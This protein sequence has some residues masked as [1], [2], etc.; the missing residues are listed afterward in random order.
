[1]GDDGDGIIGFDAGTSAVPED[2]AAASASDMLR[3]ASC[4]GS[5]KRR[6]AVSTDAAPSAWLELDTNCASRRSIEGIGRP[7]TLDETGA[8]GALAG[9]SSTNQ[10]RLRCC[11][12]RQ[13]RGLA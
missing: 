2:E 8:R 3:L 11:N 4:L 5:F 12:T 10:R 13:L 6:P 7:G 9:A 1:M